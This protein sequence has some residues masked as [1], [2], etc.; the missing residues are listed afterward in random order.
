M[1]TEFQEYLTYLEVD[2]A[3][4]KRTLQ[5]RRRALEDF[6][7]FCEA[8]DVGGVSDV[9][10]RTISKYIDYLVEEGFA[11]S[12]I[13]QAR[14]VSIGA[15][16]RFLYRE[17]KMEESVME[18][19]DK[20]AMKKKAREAMSAQERKDENEPPAHLSKEEVYELAENAGPPSDRNSLLI[21]LMFWTGVRASE[22]KL[23]EIDDI[24]LE[25]PSIEVYSPKTDTTRTVAYPAPEINPELR[26]WI[27]N[28]R[29]RYK[30]ADTSDRLFL[31]TKGPITEH[32]INEVVRD[33][34]DAAGHQ[35]EERTTKDGNVRSESTSH[36]LRHS[37]AMHYLN[38]EGKSM[39]DISQHLGHSTLSTTEKFYAQTTDERLINEFS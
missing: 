16:L 18:R 22:A 5:S 7:S 39:E 12:T 2:K 13:M 37:H 15:A 24:D 3:V 17:K 36:I 9:G 6:S 33:A 28:G 10:R 35:K 8:N 34:A 32:R 26:D 1:W 21:K 30:D 25:A 38:E 19:V 4:A 11:Y 27:R 23:I 29:L 31:G 20:K 14:F